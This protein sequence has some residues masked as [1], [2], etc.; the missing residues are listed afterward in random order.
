[1]GR[2]KKPEGHGEIKN[3]PWMLTFCNLMLL[4]I[5]FF[6]ILVA[7]S[8]V[9]HGRIVSFVKGFQ[10]SFDILPGG[11]KTDK[12]EEML[13][14][15][16]DI[17]TSD[18][19]PFGLE[20]ALD[21]MGAERPDSL[22]KGIEVYSREEGVVVN[23]SDATLFDLGSAD[24]KPAAYPMLDKIGDIIERSSFF[25]NIEGHTD[26]LPINTQRFPSNWELSA[27]R[28]VN[29]LRYFLKTKDVSSYRFSAVGYGGYRPLFPNDTPEH[30]AKNRRVMI[31]FYMNLSE[32]KGNG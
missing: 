21:L 22:T 16:K 31:V 20:Q 6:I 24:I 30:R 3:P 1:M 9:E 19:D 27:T 7:L 13:M 15:S 4:M 5:S 26:N 8:N 12:G 23:M 14:S 18:K 17:V 29:I 11:L 32:D 25:V 2:D 28:A 10:L